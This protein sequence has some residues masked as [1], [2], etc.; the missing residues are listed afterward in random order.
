MTR[1]LNRFLQ[2]SIDWLFPPVCGGCG[3]PGYHWCPDCQSSIVLI[4][5]PVC[6]ICGTPIAVIGVCEKCQGEI[7]TYQALRS[8]ASYEGAIR[9]ILISIKYRRNIF[10]GSLL[11]EPLS[12]MIL[13]LDWPVE[14]VV[15]V[16]LGKKRKQER[17]YNQVDTFARPLSK[18]LLLKYSAGA[19][20]RTRETRSQVGLPPDERFMNLHDAFWADPSIV[21]EKKILLVDDVTTTGATIKSCSNSLLMSGAEQIFAVTVAR[22]LSQRYDKPNAETNH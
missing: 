14:L 9:N 16:P 4:N 17:G 8:W 7:Q 2:D 10:L 3:K 13:D 18:L 20:K 19:I 22:A 6:K 15:P 21:C 5:E 12:K 11:A 1:Q